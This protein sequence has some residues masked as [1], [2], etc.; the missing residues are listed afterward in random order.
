VHAKVCVID[1]VWCSVGSDNLNRRSWS[2]DSELAC[3]VLDDHRDG[4]EPRDPAGLGDGARS[5]ARDLRLELW[6][7]HLGR[8]DGDDTDLLDPETGFAAFRRCAEELAA[9]HTG[10]QVGPR[11][12]GRVRPYHLDPLEQTK[13]WASAL[14]RTVYDPDGRPWKLRHADHW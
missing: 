13:A 4:R 2:H 8:E 10:G 1:D 7:E 9:W 14:Y 11:P 6:R 3:A 5:F 12:P